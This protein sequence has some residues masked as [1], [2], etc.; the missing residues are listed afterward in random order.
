MVADLIHDRLENSRA[1]GTLETYQ[2][3]LNSYLKICSENLLKPYPITESKLIAYASLAH[4]THGILGETVRNYINGVVFHCQFSGLGDPRGDGSMLKLVLNGSK[5]ID[6]QMGYQKRT[7]YGLSGSQLVSLIGKLDMNDFRAAR[8]IAYAC[9]SYFGGFR[10]NELVKS[11]AGMR[12][13]WGDFDFRIGQRDQS[14]FT[15][16]QRDSKTRQF[17]PTYNITLARTDKVNCPFKAIMNYRSFF[18]DRHILDTAPGFMDL[19]GN[20]YTYKQALADVRY[21]LP[22]I[23]E[24][25]KNFGTHSFRIGLATEAAIVEIP[26]SAVRLLG[27]WDSDCFRIYMQTPQH[28]IAEFAARLSGV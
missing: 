1:V 4:Q 7:R 19:E 21:Y 10:A 24:D 2:S 12:C 14:Y 11:K 22:F 15:I 23:N 26:D 28:K 16:V 9:V 18:T 8:F 17:G 5:R 27:R 25:G 6:H 3:G 13:H 20:A